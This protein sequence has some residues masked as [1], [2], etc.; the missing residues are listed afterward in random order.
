MDE[1][2]NSG[3]KK[4]SLNDQEDY[5]HSLEIAVELLQREVDSLRKKLRENPTTEVSNSIDKDFINSVASSLYGSTDENEVLE[6][7]HDLLIDRFNIF[8]SNIFYFNSK[9]KIYSI[10]KSSVSGNLDKIGT[11]LEEQGIIDWATSQNDVRIVPNLDITETGKTLY[12]CIVP[13]NLRGKV[14]GIYLA[15]TSKKAEEFQKDDLQELKL[16]AEYSAIAIDNII[17]SKEIKKMNRRISKYNKQ[18]MRSSQL[19]SV[20][21]LAISY[22]KEIQDPLNIIEANLDLL[23]TGVDL[24]TRIKIIKSKF[25]SLKQ[26]SSKI[27]EL[28]REQYNPGLMK[29]N[30]RKLIDEV[31]LL[32]STQMQ[33]DGIR[34]DNDIE[35]E[36]IFISANKAQLEQCI[37]NIILFSRDLMPDGGKISISA[38]NN[39][40]KK[41]TL[42]I[43]D[44]GVGLK[45][46]SI[47]NIFDPTEEQEENISANNLI[48]AKSIVEMH[49][50]I[51]K[52]HSEI[53]KGCAYKITLSME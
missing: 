2:L 17:S 15:S 38:F 43:V 48:L 52:I 1:Q 47:N 10:I 23:D 25:Q 6:T 27:N 46:E 24:E 5:I 53:G 3:N 20:G 4:E 16:V 42:S 22:F 18:I 33:R 8:E 34:I 37:L 39:N 14:V 28:T 51:F 41:V 12:Y 50:G 21:E 45:E 44:D 26:L 36:T 13:I 9:G 32:S 35:D 11:F 19:A 31:V 7:L 40:K 29:I 30:L 49:N